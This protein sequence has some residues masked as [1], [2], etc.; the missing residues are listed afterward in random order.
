[1]NRIIATLLSAAIASSWSASGAYGQTNDTGKVLAPSNVL[2]L[3]A[4]RERSSTAEGTL[5]KFIVPFAGTVRVKW[6]V[7]TDGSAP[8]NVMVQSVME[9]CAANTYSTTYE[10]GVCHLR[11][12]EGDYIEVR[13]YGAADTLVSIKNVRVYYDVL[14]NPGTIVKLR[15]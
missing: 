13:S 12:L 4:D 10:V 9:H 15:N 11:V 7:K 2:Q 14:D 5:K 3:R 1:M 6:Q 8:A